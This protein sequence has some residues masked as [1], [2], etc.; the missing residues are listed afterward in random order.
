MYFREK[1]VT[2]YSKF[3]YIMDQC[4]KLEVNNTNI[5]I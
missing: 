5:N 1:K 4:I 3:M 2:R